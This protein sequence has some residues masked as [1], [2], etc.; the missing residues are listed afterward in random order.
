VAAPFPV[1]VRL[2]ANP[3]A[4]IIDAGF[5]L[6]PM[7]LLVTMALARSVAVW[8][9]RG[10]LSLLDNDHLYRRSPDLMGGHWLPPDGRLSILKAMAA[11]LPAWQ[12]AWQYGRLAARV[13]WIGDMRHESALADRDDAS[14]LPRFE[15]CA[16]ALDARFA[17]RQGH[18]LAP[19]EECARDA[20]ALTAALQPDPVFLL[21]HAEA[22]GEP[23][24]LCAM[25]EDLGFAIRRRSGCGSRS[26]LALADPAIVALEASQGHAALVQLAAP[27]VL[28]LPESWDDPDWHGDDQG[29]TE[30]DT[31]H[32]VWRNAC[33]LWQPLESVG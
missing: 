29:G 15:H 17:L 26:A 28:T 25:L 12:R 27:A 5:A 4:F 14:L 9:P 32:D 8:L 31:D 18:D 23:P 2:G 13:H 10:L 19:L 3:P 11:E 7:G 22:Q 24:A 20:V 16:A 21:S 33:A 1:S 6:S 30:D